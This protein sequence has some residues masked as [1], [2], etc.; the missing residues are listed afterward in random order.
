MLNLSASEVLHPPD[1]VFLR[2]TL[3]RSMR[4]VEERA[5]AAAPI[6]LWPHLRALLGRES[7]QERAAHP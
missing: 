2:R 1:D 5:T 4:H 6:A 3:K 7:F